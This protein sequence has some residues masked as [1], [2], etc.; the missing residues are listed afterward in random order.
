MGLHYL[1]G[2]IESD[3]DL[4]IW[5][6]DPNRLA[7]EKVKNLIS[8]RDFS[9]DK[10]GFEF[11]ETIHSLPIDIDLCIISTTADVRPEVLLGILKNKNIRYLILEK[12]IAQNISDLELVS[13]N[14]FAIQST[15]VNLPLRS[16]T[17]F[18]R[19]KQEIE[20]NDVSKFKGEVIGTNW[21]L[22]SNSLHYID[23][24]SFLLNIAPTS[25]SLEGL[26]KIWFE[27]RLGFYDTF[28][29]IVA[30]FPN[31]SELTL[32]SISKKIG[33]QKSTFI[34]IF[35]QDKTLIIDESGGK[36]CYTQN[37]AKKDIFGQIEL[38][39]QMTSGLVKSILI[40]G[41]C[42]LPK[43]TEIEHT[44]KIYLQSLAN[45]E[46]EDIQPPNAFSNIT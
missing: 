37:G 17:W 18:N 33:S 21:N 19:I 22:I 35:M 6:T 44:H 30:H 24:F 36:A 46:T 42:S 40:D 34:N 31:N 29:S 12:L 11:S 16:M 43:F 9:N 13:K 32:T 45:L 7:L 27:S 10:M 25:I 3:L 5:V 1:R 14:L 41:I 15:W 8:S 4:K 39:S 38:Q 28:G 26:D 23:L 20:Y 2:I